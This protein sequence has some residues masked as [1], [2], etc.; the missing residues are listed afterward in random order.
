M[1]LH[2]VWSLADEEEHTGEAHR[3]SYTIGRPRPGPSARIIIRFAFN[4]RHFVQLPLSPN[5]RLYVYNMS[6]L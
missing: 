1:E 5:H 6:F 3:V 4:D 2:G